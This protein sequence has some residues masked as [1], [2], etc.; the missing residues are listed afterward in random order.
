M[1][2]EEAEDL[3]LRESKCMKYGAWLESRVLAWLDHHLHAQ[4]TLTAAYDHQPKLIGSSPVETDG[5]FFPHV[6]SD[7]RITFEL[8]DASGKILQKE[9]G[10]SSP[11]QVIRCFAEAINQAGANQPPFA[12]HNEFAKRARD[13]YWIVRKSQRESPSSS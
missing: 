9:A 11:D 10:W 8:L 5:S 3:R 1:N 13:L 6:P 12:S 7:Q 4:R 2:V